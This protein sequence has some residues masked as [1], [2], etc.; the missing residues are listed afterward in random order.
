MRKRDERA[1]GT[2]GNFIHKNSNNIVFNNSNNIIIN[3]S[4]HKLNIKKKR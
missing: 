4:N 3:N 1:A 2:K